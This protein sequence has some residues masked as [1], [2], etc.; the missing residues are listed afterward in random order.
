MLFARAGKP[1]WAVANLMISASA[2]GFLVH[3][4][5]PARVFMGDAG[6]SFLGAFYGVQS[7]IAPVGSGI[8]FI[9]FVLPFANFI[10]DA[11]FTLLR[12]IWRGEKW[13]LA[14]RSHI[15]QRMTNLGMSHKKVAVLELIAVALS[16][17]A[18]ALCVRTGIFGRISLAALVFAGLAAAGLSVIRKENDSLVGQ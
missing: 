15:Y 8:P 14:H 12:R 10:L 18:A 3:N 16:C 5:S 6:S 9:V 17:L 7:L 4:W 1:G 2:L 11:T 13:Y